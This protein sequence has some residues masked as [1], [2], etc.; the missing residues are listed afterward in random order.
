MY[1]AAHPTGPAHAP[2]HR[3]LAQV[4]AGAGIGFNLNVP[5][6]LG[7]GDFAHAEAFRRVI[8]PEVAAFRPTLIVVACGVDG[9]QF[10]PNG[11]PRRQP[12]TALP[13]ALPGA[14]PAPAA[15][16]GQPRSVWVLTLRLPKLSSV[17]QAARQ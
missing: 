6:D 3:L 17:L 13:G 15:L 7:S 16:A 14:R 4:G 5:L 8:E 11:A 9:S 10:D 1:G 2:T 12:G